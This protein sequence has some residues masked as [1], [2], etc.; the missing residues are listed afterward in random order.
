MSDAPLRCPS[1]PR[2]PLEALPGEAPPLSAHE[3]PPGVCEP[4]KWRKPG[5]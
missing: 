3:A 2:W 4:Q 1:A 5:D